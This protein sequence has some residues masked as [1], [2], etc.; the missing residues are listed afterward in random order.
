MESVDGLGLR[1]DVG[2]LIQQVEHTLHFIL[3]LDRLAFRA[4]QAQIHV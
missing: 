2:I 1:L 4:K 3:N